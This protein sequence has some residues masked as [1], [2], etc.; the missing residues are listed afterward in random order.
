LQ[1][2]DFINQYLDRGAAG[3]NAPVV[4]PSRSRPAAGLYTVAYQATA[5]RCEP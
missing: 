3:L 4:L 1:V 2:A 5:N